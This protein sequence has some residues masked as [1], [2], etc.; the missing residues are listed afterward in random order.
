MVFS[1]GTVLPPTLQT[2]LPGWRFLYSQTCTQV[3]TSTLSWSGT[4]AG[5]TPGAMSYPTVPFSTGADYIWPTVASGR[6]RQVWQ[7]TH[8]DSLHVFSRP[9]EDRNTEPM[10]WRQTIGQAVREVGLHGTPSLTVFLTADWWIPLVSR[11]T[12]GKHRVT[13]QDGCSAISLPLCMQDA[14]YN[15]P[16]VGRIKK[17]ANSPGFSRF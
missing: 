1:Q 8:S 15:G 10:K 17:E 5:E 7:P 6:E 4:H 2:L 16:T 3:K 14:F 11:V 13:F 12:A 9:L